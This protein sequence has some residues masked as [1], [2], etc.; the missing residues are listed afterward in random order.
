MNFKHPSHCI[1]LIMM[2]LRSRT[3]YGPPLLGV[4]VRQF[5][6]IDSRTVP[7]TV[8]RIRVVLELVARSDKDLT[9]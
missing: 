7:C 1:D 5:G 9:V 2:W 6:G 4:Y 8:L 3:V